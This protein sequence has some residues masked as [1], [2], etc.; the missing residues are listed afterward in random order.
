M[1]NIVLFLSRV[2][3]HVVFAVELV[4]LFAVIHGSLGF[5]K[6]TV[7]ILLLIVIWSEQRDC[8]AMMALSFYI[9]Y[10]LDDCRDQKM[11]KLREPEE[12]CN[13]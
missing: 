2:T 11:D 4:S 12:V 9:K 10:H 7:L 6:C 13:I 3:G 5:M 1:T 8:P